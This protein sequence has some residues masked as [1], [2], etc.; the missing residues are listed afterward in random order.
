MGDIY[1]NPP[2]SRNEAI[3]RATIDRTEYEAP[4]QS[5]IEDLLIELKEAIE[6]GACTEN[7]NDLSNKPQI[8]GVT[9][10]GNKSLKDLSAVAT[11]A[12]QGL[13]DTEKSN[14]R[15]NIDTPSNSDIQSSITPQKASVVTVTD[16]YPMDA[17]DITV[18][19]EPV[20]DLHGYDKPWPGGAGK[21][22][23]DIHFALTESYCDSVV[24][25][26]AGQYIAS[27]FD[28]N[29]THDGLIG[30]VNFSCFLM[31]SNAQN[32]KA[33]VQNGVTITA[34]EA[35]QITTLRYYFD[36]GQYSGSSNEFFGQ[37]E[38]GNQA[39]SYAPYSN[40]CPIEGWV[41][42]ELDRVG[43]NQ[44]DEE[45]ESGL[46]DYTTGNKTSGNG[47][48]SKN[49]ISIKANTN[50]YAHIPVW[51]RIAFYDANK[52]Y[53]SGEQISTN[54]FITPTNAKYMKLSTNALYGTTYN[55]DIS[56]NYPSTDTQYHAYQGI[57]RT[58][59]FGQTVYGGKCHATEGGTDVTMASVDMGSLDWYYNT[60]PVDY[61]VANLTDKKIGFD[62]II[63]SI[64]STS[65]ASNIQ[66]Q[67]LYSV[68]VSDSN[69]YVYVKDNR[70]TSASEFKT[71]VT[72][73]KLVYELATPTTINTDA[74]D[75]PMLEGINTI[76]GSTGDVNL[77]YQPDNV[78]GEL[79][80][81]IQALDAR[82]T[83]LEEA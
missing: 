53:I 51:Y 83:A 14:A 64:Y 73:Q 33:H 38:E 55:H 56:I 76:S 8:N 2:Q 57:S 79:K 47:I 1:T 75:I 4:P 67:P 37:L 32:I 20:Q 40:I 50:Y 45:W 62:N 78:I 46:I 81:M 29:Y 82:V 9:L 35:S 27:L 13:T 61:F 59:N 69:A 3:L 18:D 12:D 10:E 28:Q 7:Y 30:G 65:D 42:E 6:Q 44:W 34:E 63:A 11:S 80:G 24:H 31:D 41:G 49:Y 70:Y 68:R 54:I 58:V 19:I 22:K 71:A 52:I 21:N 36:R 17:E 72:G 39:T 23:A 74:V 43:I 77:K 48:R 26:S 25:L 16:A 60:S 15:T 66:S 5:R